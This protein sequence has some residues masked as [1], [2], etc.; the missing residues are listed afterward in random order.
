MNR[1]SLISSGFRRPGYLLVEGLVSVVMTVFAVWTVVAMISY[2]SQVQNRQLVNFHSY[3]RILESE[4]FDFQ[5]KQIKV[6]DTLLYSPVTHKYYHMEKYK[7]MIR[8]TGSFK[9]H[10]PALN[11]VQKVRWSKFRGC[12]RTDVTFNNG[13]KCSAY[14]KLPFKD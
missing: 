13:Q 14:S 3:I 11:D 9:G 5:I 8:F 6:G 12:L 1:K 7:G 4:K 10:I 2:A